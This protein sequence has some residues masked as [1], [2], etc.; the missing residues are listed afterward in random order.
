[1]RQ[2]IELMKVLYGV[3]ILSPPAN[4][5]IAPSAALPD[6]RPNE[7]HGVQW[8]CKARS[9]G[10]QLLLLTEEI[11][12]FLCSVHTYLVL[13][14]S[15]TFIVSLRLG[16][17]L[18]STEFFVLPRG[19]LT[20]TY[21]GMYRILSATTNPTL[22]NRL[23]AGR[24]GIHNIARDN[25]RTSCSLGYKTKTEELSFVTV[26][27]ICNKMF[28]CCCLALF[29]IVVNALSYI[30]LV[31]RNVTQTEKKRTSPKDNRLTNPNT[32][33]ADQKRCLHE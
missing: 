17:I 23:E 19:E 18:E 25:T 20:I 32:R 33:E 4:L 9:K 5:C 21:L 30:K 14:L 8:R 27:L 3:R 11:R 7:K 31:H 28:K 10:S 6:L 29:I 26:I 12:I 13:S 2:P 16:G 24:K 22:K 15:N 1:M